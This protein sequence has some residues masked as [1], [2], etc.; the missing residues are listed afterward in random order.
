M[1]EKM[2]TKR[3]S[4]D[5]YLV[6][7][8]KKII[9][10]FLNGLLIATNVSLPFLFSSCIPND[11][12]REVYNNVKPVIK[13]VEFDN[14]HTFPGDFILNIEG[15]VEK[16]NKVY[17][18]I[19]LN[20]KKYKQG[21][22]NVEDGK[23]KLS[24]LLDS[25]LYYSN[26]K[27]LDVDV[28][29]SLNSDLSTPTTYSTEL[30][31]PYPILGTKDKSLVNRLENLIEEIKEGNLS[32]YKERIFDRLGFLKIN[33]DLTFYID[34]DG[35]DYLEN[36]VRK[37]SII[38]LVVA[39]VRDDKKS[40]YDIILNLDFVEN[41]N[42]GLAK[43]YVLEYY[44]DVEGA[45]GLSVIEFLNKYFS[46]IIT[47]IDENYAITYD[48][49]HFFEKLIEND[50]YTP[51]SKVDDYLIVNNDNMFFD[52]E[53]TFLGLRI[54]QN[55][56]LH[57]KEIMAKHPVEE[58]HGVLV[59]SKERIRKIL[60]WFSKDTSNL[61][62]IGAV[63]R[64]SVD[65]IEKAGGPALTSPY[66]RQ[67]LSPVGYPPWYDVNF[68]CLSNI[69]FDDAKN[70]GYIDEEATS[71]TPAELASEDYK[72]SYNKAVNSLRE[73][74]EVISKYLNEE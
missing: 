38:N 2:K 47:P 34:Y 55:Y 40:T 63:R 20:E 65:M 8:S 24:T 60:L 6:S 23:F 25:N 57:G 26:I 13:S 12:K 21:S 4:I 61:L 46:G 41:L 7:N 59:G 18:L 58:L 62:T 29:L 10:K 72:Y 69:G 45:G 50:K 70:L 53:S 31:K 74:T 36:G 1:G 11:S 22:V 43:Y 48:E 32:R 71:M 49:D 15:S 35:R 68:D 37:N 39:K 16:G 33:D 27:P 44:P 64:K 9:K 28:E 14:F 73:A 66:L 30:T 42:D 52:K 17:Y 19:S 54:L 3:T 51:V 5:D 67:T 56:A